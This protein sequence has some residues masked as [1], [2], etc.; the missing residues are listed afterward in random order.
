MPINTLSMKV[1]RGIIERAQ[2]IVLYGPEGIGKSTL[3][4]MF[5]GAVFLDTEG[6]TAHMDVARLECPDTFDKLV[7]LIKAVAEHPDICDTLVIDTADWAEQMAIAYILKKYDM[8]SI[9]SFGYGKGYTY[10]GEE[11]KKL[12]D[13]L[14]LVIAAGINVVVT[15]HAKMRKFEQ[16]DEIG[17]YDRWEMK[18]SKQSAPLLKEWCDHLF[19]CN[20]QTM[21]VEMENKTKK[22]QGGKRVIYTAHRPVWDAKTRAKLPEVVDM[23]FKSIESILPMYVQ[24]AEPKRAKDDQQLQSLMIAYTVTE[25]ELVSLIHDKAPDTKA[26]QT[27]KEMPDDRIAWCIK[28]WNKIADI[29]NKSKEDNENV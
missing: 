14:D 1:I 9:E 10:V 6:G 24:K 23:N 22:A 19:F 15:A 3:A 18:L 29:I 16:P 11:F 13:A 7:E 27:L 28:W 5:P 8:T 20:Y 17:A 26:I 12:L 25:E 21:V 4:S 2:K